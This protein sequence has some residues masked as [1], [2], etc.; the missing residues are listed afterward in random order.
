M[1]LPR[2]FTIPASAPFV[3][4]LLRALIDGKLVLG[5]PAARD[6]LALAG[7]TLYLPTRRA[8]RLARDLFLDVTGEGAAILPRIVAVGDVDEDEIIFAQAATGAIATEALELPQ[9]LG[10]L[11][12]RLLLAQLVRQW[13]SG[14]APDKKGE[15][16]LVANN[17]ASA[18]ALADDLARLMDDMTTRAVPWERLDQI[19]PENLDRYW[20]LTL[21][22]L[23]IAR[24]TWP[25]ILAERG[26]IEPAARRDALIKAEAQR[27][28]AHTD[29]PVIAAGST[30]SMPATAELI[31]TIAKLAHGAVVL[32]G[33]DTD[34][35]ADSWELIG[36]RQDAAGRDIE[37]PAV[38]HPQFAMQSLLR[39]IGIAREEVIALAVPAVGGRERYVS[40]ALRPARATDRW[41]ELATSDFPTRIE[42]ALA[43]LAVIEAATAEEEALAIAVA[44]RETLETPDKT[45][46]L[47]TP[48]RALARRTLAAL[49][50]WN[51]AVDDSGGDA[52]ADTPAGLF[53]RLAA[54]AALGA[55]A[56]V[57]LLALLKHPLTRLGAAEGAHVSAVAAL[58]RAVLRGPRPR[59]GTRGL[60]QALATFRAEL[61]KLRRQ[62][63][64]DLH[65]ADPRTGLR[66]YEL[67]AATR[68]VDRLAA[69]LAPL[70]ALPR[71][72]RAFAEIAACHREVVVALSAEQPE[73]PVAFAGTDGTALAAVFHDIALHEADLAVAPAD[74]AELFRTAIADRMVRR[75]GLPGVRVRIYG[76]LEARLQSVDRMVLGGLV[77]GIWPPD[78]RTDPW[79]NRPMRHALGLDLPER[80]ISLSAHDFAQALGAQEV[81]LSYPAKLA[82][83][84]TV[85]SRFVQRLAAVAGEQHWSDVRKRGERYLD[86]TRALD[87]PIE[88]Q[89]LKKPAPKPPRDARPLA[90]SVTDIE[91]WLRDPY[92][93]YAKYILRLRELD[94]VDLAP[95]AADRG[96]V[97]H[98][99]LREFTTT[100]AAALPNDPEAALL[101]IGRKHFAALDDYPEARAFW[102]PRFERIARWLAGWEVERRA[103]VAAVT[104]EVAGKIEIPV[105][106]RVFTLRTR[107]DRIERLGERSYA[108]LDYKTGQV[109]T[110][111]QVR[112][113]ISPQLTLE[114]AI[115]R[116]GGF[117]GIAA[118]ASVADLA[119]ISLRGG[120]PAGEEITMDFKD[121][122][123]NAHA[124]RALGKLG[125]LATRFEDEQQPY[126]SLVLSMW[127]NRYGT[128]DH[129]ARVKE[130]TVGGDD[131]DESGGGE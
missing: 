39:R 117:G 118:G 127:K 102:W 83:A 101:T 62:E 95:G 25:A 12:R 114:A 14:I 45:A 78:T 131:E 49:A 119:Y 24:D 115:L 46:A 48:D 9:P 110:E 99:A 72:P 36:G 43:T 55:L 69:A 108:I 29:G 97:I 19:V 65:P 86:W 68:L 130:W 58:E 34:L 51:V 23:K 38:G 13:A 84:P 41:R 8:C 1:A 124:D 77:E 89:R 26:R 6:P 111:K 74:Y 103:N 107:A 32:P 113:G 125:T 2:V 76:A 123:A 20:Q 128:Y 40:E 85:T 28:A 31:A 60:A 80:R 116:G 42:G 63:P 37:P 106:E 56:P 75:P 112:V 15:A 109:P 54:E 92:T 100:F 96:I 61:A 57:S 73:K 10:G 21:A 66:D 98:S 44:L 18:L 33:L 105:G 67:D 79:L 27:L 35:D 3:P 64:S 59:P 104:A 122:D 90:L 88:V 82:G 47:V 71:A 70:E 11:E 53:A 121:G 5:F 129:L 17:P 93:I 91:S 94:P 16:A 81:I 50:R 30:G 87:R 4:T 7:A 120:V 126:R 22:F 52:L